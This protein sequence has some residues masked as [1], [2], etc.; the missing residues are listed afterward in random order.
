MWC[1]HTRARRE[2]SDPSHP[3]PVVLIAPP[4]CEAT[5]SPWSHSR[6]HRQ[7]SN[8]L[9]PPFS[10]SGDRIIADKGMWTTFNKPCVNRFC[11]VFVCE[12]VEGS[13]LGLFVAF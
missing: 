3:P 9:P 5:L 12:F 2:R 11:T 6:A 1:Y 7:N 13:T 4:P 10:H 8:T